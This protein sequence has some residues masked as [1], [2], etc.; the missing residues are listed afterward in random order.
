MSASGDRTV[1]LV[2]HAHALPRGSWTGPDR[3]RRL[4]ARGERQAEVIG[5]RL[6]GV[7]PAAIVSSPAERC[8]ATL[9]QLAARTGLAIEEADSLEEGTD[10]AAALADLV[11]RAE[12]LERGQSLV[13]CSHGDVIHGILEA[14]EPVGIVPAS[15]AGVPKG[16]TWELAVD[17]GWVSAARFVAAPPPGDGSALDG[18]A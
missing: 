14:L 1:H 9:R 11:Q 16:S 5:E 2:R 10:P 7:A 18:Q 4:S 8:L 12:K 6:A 17:D 3:A 15:A 13:A